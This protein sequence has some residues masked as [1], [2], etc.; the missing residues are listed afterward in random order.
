MGQGPN[1]HRIK[2]DFIQMK[3]RPMQIATPTAS[4]LHR[5]GQ[6][7][8]IGMSR[9][10]RCLPALCALG[11]LTP[12]S[13][14]AQ[15]TG[16]ITGSVVDAETGFPI[17]GAQVGIPA[18]EIGILSQEGGRFVLAGVPA[19][20]HELTVER[21]GLLAVARSVTVLAGEAAVVEI[22]MAPTVLALEG[23]VVTG[24]AFSESPVE[25]PYAVAVSGRRT[26]AEQGSPQAVDFFRNLGSSAGVLGDR[27]GWYTT[28]PTAAVAETVASVNL[29]GIGPSRTLVLL[30]GRRQVYLPARLLG[31]R[32]V[33]V[34]SFPAIALDRIEVVKEGASAI[35]GSD[36]VA[37]VANFLTRSE[38]EGIELSGAHEYVAD[39][40]QTQVG[41]IWGVGLGNDFHAVLSAEAVLTRAL[42]P[43]NRDWALR[44][45][46][47]GG[48]AW[49]Y[50][51]N[52]G[53]FLFPRL[54]GDESSSE[55]VNA[56]IDAQ[57]GGWGG[58]FVDPGCD[59]FGG[60]REAETCRFR[61]Q[62]WDNLIQQS[63]QLRAFGEING[64]LGDRSRIHIEALWAEGTTPD[65][66]TTPSFPP[67]SPYNGAQ[68][69]QPGNPGRPVFC[70]M[71]G[72]AAGFA[73]QDDCM[74]GDW[75]FYGRLVGNSGPGRSL[76]RG[77]QTGRIAAS[78]EREID[79][80]GSEEG[81]LEFAA[82]YSRASGNAN[83]PAEYAYRK[84]L[85]FRGF[86]G[87]GCG[88]SVVVDP[89]S[90]SGMALGPLNGAVA[91]QDNCSW[92][93]PFSNALQFSAQPGSVHLDRPNPAWAPG[94]ANSPE[95]LAWINEVVDLESSSDLLVG[96]AMLRGALAERRLEYA[97]G[98]QFRRVGV[99]A[100]PN[101]PGNLS[102]NPCPVP[103]DRSCIEKA[104]PFTFTTGHY[105]YAASQSVHRFFTETRFALGSRISGQA[106]ANYEFHG[107]V[108]SFDPKLAMRADLPGPLALRASLQTTFRTPSVDD[109]NEDRN[110]SL[111]YVAE[112]GIYKAFDTFGNRNLEPERALTWNLGLTLELPR[113]RA[114]ADYWSY[115]FRD[116]IDALPAAGMTR[117]YAAGGASRAAVQ[118]FVTC[119]DGRGT[120]SCDVTAIERVEITHVNWPGIEMSGLDY[121][122]SARFPAGESVVALGVDGTWLNAFSVKALDLNGVEIFTAQ[123]AVGKLNWNNPIAPP[124]PRWKSRLSAAWH[125]GDFSAVNY[126]NLVSGYANEVFPDSEFEQIDRFVTWDLGLLRRTSGS[127]DLAF[128][129]INLLNADPP[130]VNWEQSY[131]GFTHDP[132]GIRLK[133][134]AIWRPQSRFA[135]PTP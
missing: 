108:N 16:T 131:D 72:A 102:L 17:V 127:V 91:G 4:S 34:N 48:G 46:T 111:E 94:L 114:S 124:L 7:R 32:F 117:L 27:Q 82:S 110:T 52:P 23:V 68:V 18:L 56:L 90:P 80:L 42:E 39:A 58:V 119:P 92:Y 118:E 85:A 107:S 60:H 133:L 105:E 81:R 120:G 14:A 112:A 41:A 38:F 130:L 109:L 88:V 129:A 122:L 10:I 35:Y 83:L 116:L 20:T 106:A 8:S 98:Y 63:R 62:P 2:P 71:H 24:T 78:L 134:S 5:P 67:I 74:N 86:G 96:D 61:Y 21:I 40:G 76:E 79:W 31:G 101:D 121:H 6:P 93:N 37:G 9:W 123:D 55:F 69:I 47:P 53:A 33:D 28:R 29:R 12:V 43:E 75:Y 128:S 36:A 100:T 103:G 77:T 87:P 26:L 1:H 19:G 44:D 73:S 132:R 95:L 70:Q 51:G 104:G 84:F 59:D 15:D 65:W 49:S 45:F 64:D 25:L 57:F 97:V 30:N 99:A 115:D 13:L 125:V 113:V 89:S 135:P 3:P 126:L 66:V 50:T 54:N 22:R 11:T